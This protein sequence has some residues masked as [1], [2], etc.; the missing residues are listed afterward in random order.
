MAFY[1]TIII[2]AGAAG[3]MAA[4]TAAQKG[5]VLILE[6]ME[7]AARKVRI[8]GKG[9]CNITNTKSR[10][11]FL[12]KIYSG[13]EFFETAFDNFNNHATIEFLEE[14]GLPV[15]AERGDR[16][17]PTSG[18]AWDV[19][20]TL[21]DAAIEAGAKIEYFAEVERLL[22]EDKEVVGVELKNGQT[23]ECSN[24]IVATG[25][26][27]YPA[28]GS[29]GDGYNMAYDAGHN[30]EPVRPSL[31][32]LESDS[33]MVKQL[34][35]TKLINIRARL[36][37]DDKIKGEEFGEMEFMPFGV[38]G[39]IVLRMS[40]TAV[41]AIID[42]R[43]VELS[44][45]LKPALSEQQLINR[46]ERELKSLKSTDQIKE[47]AHSLT[48]KRMVSPLLYQ[49][50]IP[51][52]L[53]MRQFDQKRK[54]ALISTLKDFRIPITDYRPYAEAIVTAGGVDLSEVES[55]SMGSKLIRGLFFAGELLDLD[56]HTGGYNLQIAFSTGRLAGSSVSTQRPQDRTVPYFNRRRG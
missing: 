38:S 41:D 19:A 52:M 44:L 6:K 15:A 56:A 45:D 29:T 54:E 16:V 28:T 22:I 9:R 3:L 42:G 10:E 1:N 14:C 4:T 55:K 31:T 46:I 49:A 40:R 20:N 32:P 47:L 48:P 53:H 35:G 34:E 24:V 43:K 8:S 12:A 11:D 39:A 18:K 50:R 33:Q 17:F 23:I 51:L 2:G 37:V 26:L 7:K 5:S 21:V 30:I 25:G 13:A 36:L 27:S